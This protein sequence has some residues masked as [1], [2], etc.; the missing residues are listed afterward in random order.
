LQLSSH[1]VLAENSTG[2][3]EI[4][5]GIGAEGPERIDQRHQVGGRQFGLDVVDSVE[6]EPV[7]RRKDTLQARASPSSMA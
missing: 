3:F 5:S 7:A 6:D 1:P 2:S 4:L